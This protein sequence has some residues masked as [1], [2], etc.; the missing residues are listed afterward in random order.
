[1]SEVSRMGRGLITIEPDER[2]RLIHGNHNE[3][4]SSNVPACIWLLRS[5]RVLAAVGRIFTFS[6]LIIMFEKH[7]P[8]VRQREASHLRLQN[9]LP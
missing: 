8:I 4:N 3:G 2:S 6:F 5:D 1:M 9:V 7:G